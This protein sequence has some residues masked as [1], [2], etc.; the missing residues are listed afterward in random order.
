MQVKASPTIVEDAPDLLEI[1]T[2]YMGLDRAGGFGRRNA[3]PGELVVQVRPTKLVARF[4][5]AD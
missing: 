3:A 1:A 5:I 2:Q 4:N